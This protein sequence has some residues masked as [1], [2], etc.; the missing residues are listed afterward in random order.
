MKN[1]N[2]IR[3][4]MMRKIIPTSLAESEISDKKFPKAVIS[5]IKF[6][7]KRNKGLDNRIR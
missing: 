7:E 4:G 3:N 5:R 2:R 1:R 6:I